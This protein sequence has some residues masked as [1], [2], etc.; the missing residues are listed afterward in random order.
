MTV[1]QGI[2][3]WAFPNLSDPRQG[4][5]YELIVPQ[6]THWEM[7]GIDQYINLEKNL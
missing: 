2:K 7:T 5:P 1:Q 4:A 6:N 3:V